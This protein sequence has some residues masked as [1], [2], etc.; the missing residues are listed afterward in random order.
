MPVST[1]S[2]AHRDDDRDVGAA[3]LGG[4]RRRHAVRDQDSTLRRTSSSA[5]AARRSAL[6]SVHRAS[7]TRLRPT[8]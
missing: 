4:E 3:R 8:T 1:M 7:M 6:P 5:R 2:A